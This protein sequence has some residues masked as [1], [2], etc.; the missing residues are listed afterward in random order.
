MYIEKN[1]YDFDDLLLVPRASRL[2]SREEV[3]LG[4]R[5]SDHLVL[6]LPVIGSPMK[7]I[8]SAKLA[9]ELYKAGGIGILHRFYGYNEEIIQDAY[10]LHDQ[11]ANF[12]IAIGLDDEKELEL[13]ISLQPAI[14]C[15]DVANGYL[16]SVLAYTN[17]VR[18]TLE[19]T[20]QRMR[21]A[22]MVGN[23]IDGMG[24]KKLANS[25][26]DIVRVGIGSGGL[27]T[28]RNMTG[29]GYPQLS[30]IRN[31]CGYI[32]TFRGEKRFTGFKNFTVIADGGI[33]NSGDA[34]KAIA[35]GADAVMLGSY[36]GKAAESSHNGII[37][38][39]ASRELQEEYYHNVKSVEGMALP[40]EKTHPA[41]KL[42][43][44]FSWGMKSAC[45]YLN[46]GNLTQLRENATWVET[47]KGTIK[48]L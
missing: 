42:L 30:A 8:M 39:M 37:M 23:V 17:T 25:G 3:Y 34:V 14:I 45:T 28:T 20:F 11:G 22:L 7:G 35:M 5:I 31:S 13:V 48:Q 2:N 33:R 9:N 24:A 38:G 41:S 4:T 15:I 27:C 16:N 36:L 10:W 1:A 21:P 18:N 29:V 46:A 40:V 12:G 32:D 19:R 26:A 43:E 47:G 44:E 6:D